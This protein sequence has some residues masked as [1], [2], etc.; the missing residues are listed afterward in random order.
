MVRLWVRKG[1]G[2]TVP[3]TTTYLGSSL[4]NRDDLKNFFPTRV[5]KMHYSLLETQN[6]LVVMNQ[7]FPLGLGSQ[8]LHDFNTEMGPL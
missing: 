6:K 5:Q 2:D 3:V 7:N 8:K 1:K 4:Q